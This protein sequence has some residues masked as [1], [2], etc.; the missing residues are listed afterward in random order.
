MQLLPKLIVDSILFLADTI[1]QPGK[2]AQANHGWIVL[3]NGM[4]AVHVGT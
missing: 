1:V 3:T 4:E 2:I